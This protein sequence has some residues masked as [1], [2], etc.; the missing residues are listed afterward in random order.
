[1]DESRFE[2]WRRTRG[3]DIDLTEVC[4]SRPLPANTFWP[5]EMILYRAL[6]RK[7]DDLHEVPART[8]VDEVVPDGT[9]V[10]A[11]QRVID[12]VQR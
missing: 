9:H 2:Q 3:I 1:M 5:G 10:L 8:D 11:E 4:H 6:P 12:V 7:I